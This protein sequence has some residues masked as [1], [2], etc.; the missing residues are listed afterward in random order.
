MIFVH[1]GGV[2]MMMLGVGEATVTGDAGA[3]AQAV[4]K[5]DK[6]KIKDISLLGIL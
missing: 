1:E 4:T 6:R 2:G 3:G 5:A